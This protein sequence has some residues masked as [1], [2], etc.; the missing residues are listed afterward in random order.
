[1]QF[2]QEDLRNLKVLFQESLNSRWMHTR[3]YNLPYWSI[4]TIKGIV[5]KQYFTTGLSRY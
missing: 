3:L 5:M 1:M 4:K 2:K